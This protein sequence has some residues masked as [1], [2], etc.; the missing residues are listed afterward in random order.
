MPKVGEAWYDI[1]ARID[2]LRQGLGQAD[3]DVENTVRRGEHGFSQ[4]LTSSIGTAAGAI[5]GFGVRVAAVGAAVFGA[6][7][8]FAIRGA[9][10]MET[11]TAQWEVLLGSTELAKTRMDELRRFA[12]TTPFEIPEVIQASRV[13][14]IF[15]GDVLATG[16]NLRMVGDIAAGVGQPFNDVAMWV[17]RM[18]DAIESGTPFGE[19]AMRLQEM[20][21]M[22]GE[23]RRDIEELAQQ[24][25]DGAITM[26][27]A[28]A[29]VG[30]EFEQFGGLMERQSLTLAG[31][32]SN[33]MDG[34]GQMM[35]GIGEVFMPMV[36]DAV[37]GINEAMPSI[38]ENL[39][40]VA[41]RIRDVIS[42]VVDWIADNGPLLDQ[43]REF[44]FGALATMRDIVVSLFEG[45]GDL[46]A[47]IG[48]WNAA[49]DDLLVTLA[50]LTAESIISG[51]ETLI[52]VIVALASNETTLAIG[53]LVGG[54]I[55][56]RVALDALRAHPIIGT[57]ALI[58]TGIGLL[59]EAWDN[60][61]QGIRT[62]IIEAWP[63]IRSVLDAIYV[64]MQW[65]GRAVELIGLGIE[66]MW[67]EIVGAVQRGAEVLLGTLAS[68]PGPQQEAMQAAHA[69]IKGLADNTEIEGDRIEAEMARIAQAPIDHLPNWQLGVDGFYQSVEGAVNPTA[70]A[71]RRLASGLIVPIDDIDLYQS[72]ARAVGTFVSG[73]TDNEW[74]MQSA[75]AGAAGRFRD[76]WPSSEPRDPSSPFR[77]ITHWG[78][79]AADIIIEGWES[80]IGSARDVAARFAS[81]MEKAARRAIDVTAMFTPTMADRPGAAFAM[82]S[83]GTSGGVLRAEL[84]I[85]VRGDPAAIGAIPGGAPAL[86]DAIGQR[87]DLA[88]LLRNWRHEASAS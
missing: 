49:N 32:W 36:K 20:G 78:A 30:G 35:A 79:G 77:G 11:F 31:Q 28:W 70:D 55:A 75:A 8:G 62:A 81:E 27:E 9:A 42:A 14:Q 46:A 51:L 4:R 26:E 3:R 38:R 86:A 23:T 25:S 67:T 1:E 72:G 69:A 58:V 29:R 41:E 76:V 83:A 68:I 37:D 18:Y 61:W 82:A 56:L 64:G 85:D 43:I 10:Q 17:G 53:A 5:I 87:F 84:V 34:L 6:I 54:F 7:G 71:G 66:L 12:A 44:A 15:G 88:T 59:K 80:R 63:E 39:V 73:I 45:I 74:R 2:R 21:A 24:V 33:L 65:F 57:L 22:S 13:L 48:D 16:D 50:G 60:D 19:A 40:G 52:D 47:A